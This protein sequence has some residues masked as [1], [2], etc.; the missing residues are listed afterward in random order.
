[1]KR[2]LPLHASGVVLGAPSTRAMGRAVD[3]LSAKH[4]SLDTHVKRLRA[5]GIESADA[6]FADDL[7]SVI[8]W[9]RD[10]GADE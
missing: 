3:V 5:T 4:W 10:L 9:L 1:M 2:E 7:A 8:A 6:D